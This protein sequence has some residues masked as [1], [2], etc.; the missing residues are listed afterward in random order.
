MLTQLPTTGENL[1][2]ICTFHML[3]LAGISHVWS[4]AFSADR[5]FLAFFH[6]VVVTLTAVTPLYIEVIVDGASGGTYKEFVIC[7]FDGCTDFV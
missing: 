3:C 5:V 2:A 1:R 6:K 4:S 7:V